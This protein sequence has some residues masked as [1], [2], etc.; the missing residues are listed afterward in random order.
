MTCGHPFGKRTSAYDGSV[1]FQYH[2]VLLSHLTAII[3][4]KLEDLFEMQGDPVDG[5]SRQM[6][7]DVSSQGL[8]V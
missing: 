8:K 7:E 1:A 5:A 6:S 3:W 4:D 2:A